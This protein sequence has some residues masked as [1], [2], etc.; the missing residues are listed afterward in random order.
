MRRLSNCLAAAAFALLCAGC[1][2]QI[3]HFQLVQLDLG[4]SPAATAEKLKNPPLS[5]HTVTVEQVQY[6]FHRYTM[7]NGLH[8]DLYLLA[9]EDGNRLRYWGYVDEFRRHPD[10]RIN[11]AIGAALP[12]IT[13]AQ[14]AR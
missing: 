1:A 3:H 12:Q 11:K 7:N 14:K 2:P 9:F 6:V 4:M 5:V 10:K 8:A 13:A